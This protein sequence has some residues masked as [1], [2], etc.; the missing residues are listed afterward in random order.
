LAE[1]CH[2]LYRVAG[3][4]DELNFGLLEIDWD[5]ESSLE[6]VMTAMTK[7]GEAAFSHT[8]ILEQ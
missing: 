2:S 6:I 1:G 4:Y 3:A 7:N 5:A 8:L